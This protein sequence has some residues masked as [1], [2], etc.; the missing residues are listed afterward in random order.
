MSG[1]IVNLSLLPLPKVLSLWLLTLISSILILE[2]S[3]ALK[4]EQKAN[5]NQ[6]LWLRFFSKLNILINSSLEIITGKRF[7]SLED[8]IRVLLSSLLKQTEKR[9]LIAHKLTL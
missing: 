9:N 2:I 7:L 6:H 5:N 8:G 3:I 4:P 1:R